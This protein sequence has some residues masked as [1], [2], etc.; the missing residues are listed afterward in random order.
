[1]AANY[2]PEA[3]VI[4]RPQALPGFTGRKEMRR[5]LPKLLVKSFGSTENPQVILG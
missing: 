1:M 4:R 3:S 5:R 2:V